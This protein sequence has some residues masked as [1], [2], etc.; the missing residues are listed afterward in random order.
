MVNGDW[1]KGFRDFGHICGRGWRRWRPQGAW[2][3]A[4]IALIA[5]ALALRWVHLDRPIYWHDEMATSVRLAGL[6]YSELHGNLAGSVFPAGSLADWYDLSPDRGWGAAWA[7]LRS[8]PEHPPL[9]FLLVRGWAL[10][11]G[12]TPVG[13]R[14]LS[15]LI[16][17][18]TIPAA[19]WLVRELGQ[20]A[21]HLHPARDAH[22]LAQ[23]QRRRSLLLWILAVELALSPL[24]FA[25]AREARQ[26]A[27][28]VVLVLTSGAALVRAMRRDTGRSW[29]VY[30]LVLTAAIYTHLFS[31]LVAL[32]HGLY[33][34]WVSRWR[35]RP[36]WGHL[37]MAWLG[38][39]I[40]FAPWAWLLFTNPS[41]DEATGWLFTPEPKLMIALRWLRAFGSWGWERSE[42]W[43]NMGR[44][45]AV[46]L[47]LLGL[48]IGSLI[49]VG[50]GS[51]R[52][53]KAWV[54]PHAV[55]PFAMLSLPALLRGNPLALIMR[56]Q[57]PAI[58]A[59]Q[60]AI[61]TVLAAGWQR[62]GWQRPLALFISTA[63][64]LLHL[65]A[66][67]AHRQSSLWWYRGGDA[68]MRV[69][70]QDVLKNG[71][72]L[73]GDFQDSV[74]TYTLVLGSLLPPE[75]PLVWLPTEDPMRAWP[76]DRD[77]LL[78]FRPSWELRTALEQEASVTL[79]PTGP[80]HLQLWAA[81]RAPD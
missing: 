31:A 70:S 49:W 27:L 2:Q 45:D 35:W 47:G 8:R 42:I 60:I 23:R 10:L 13:T 77:R 6:S 12:N 22:S 1:V 73:A 43:Q 18:L 66:T 69:Q 50:R 39:A 76:S 56:Y 29:L 58:L 24:H 63:L 61:A 16:S 32:A 48:V 38:V 40:V 53:L 72:M 41:V 75:T 7:Q 54:L 79:A 57:F 65:T 78:L 64:L 51:D 68:V 71:T 33:A 44:I 81:D 9:Y 34:A 14:S 25:Y 59:I 20:A 21:D 52:P 80:D 4:T 62:R 28:W 3:W 30:G 36:Q 46:P 37:G 17:Y 15:V 26:Y 55:I 11:F 67:H 19:I 5:I 74:W